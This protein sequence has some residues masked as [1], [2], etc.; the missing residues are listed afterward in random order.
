MYCQVCG[1][2]ASKN[3]LVNFLNEE[4]SYN[5]LPDSSV[6]NINSSSLLQSIDHIKLFTSLNPFDFGVISYLHSQNDILSSGGSVKT[7]SV[8]LALPFSKGIIESFF[9]KYFMKGIDSEAIND[10]STIVS[11]HSYQS[12]EP[13]HNYNEWGL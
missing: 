1:S 10:S 8:S 13:G 4:S 3:T 12:K 11:G 5:D 9:M 7:I 2:K 6:I